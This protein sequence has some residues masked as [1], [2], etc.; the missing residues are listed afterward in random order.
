MVIVTT[1]VA[2]ERAGCLVG[3][4]AQCSID[5]PRLMVWLSEKNRTTRV[6]Q[7]A[8]SLLVHFLARDDHD[9]AALFGGRT[10]DE[11][12]KFSRCRWRPGPAGLP[13][14]DHCQR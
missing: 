6:A 14:L 13:L 9:L 1:A 10:G 12:D 5:P 11:V 2:G 8:G 7:G 4:S 3:F